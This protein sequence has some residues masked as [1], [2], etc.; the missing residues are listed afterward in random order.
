[1]PLSFASRARNRERNRTST[2]I[3][4]RIDGRRPS[5]ESCLSAVRP[6]GRS[7]YRLLGSVG[8]LGDGRC[9]H[10][11]DAARPL[12]AGGEHQLE[13][14]RTRGVVERDLLGDLALHHVAEQGLV[15]GAHAVVLAL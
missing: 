8:R 9:P 11:L 1:M 3:G 7:S 13:V 5:L 14:V 10:L 4:K 6:T 2:G 15:E 12:A